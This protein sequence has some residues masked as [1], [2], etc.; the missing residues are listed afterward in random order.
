[1]PNKIVII[2]TTVSSLQQAEKI[3]EQ[4]II[5]KLA[6]CANIVPQAISIYEWQGKLEKSTECLIILKTSI[7][8]AKLLYKWLLKNH[9]YDVP[10]ILKITAETSK[11]FNNYVIAQT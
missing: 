4:V 2:Y 1:M 9:P 8:K 11:D 6:A 5:T 3:A 7:I 10:A